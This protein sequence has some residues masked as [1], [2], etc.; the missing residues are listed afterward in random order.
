LPERL[1]APFYLLYL[2]LRRARGGESLPEEG[3]M[4]QEDK[5]MIAIVIF[6]ILFTASFGW[7][8]WG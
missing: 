7:G 5:W 4:K 1:K 3:P 8:V 6:S 2:P